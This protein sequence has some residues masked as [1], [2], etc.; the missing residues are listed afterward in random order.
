MEEH[1]LL[2]EEIVDLETA[3]A[4]HFNAAGFEDYVA[5]GLWF[6]GAYLLEH[7]ELYAPCLPVDLHGVEFIDKLLGIGFDGTLGNDVGGVGGANTD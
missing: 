1:G 4:Q 7:Q 3:A 6:V 5:H 2:V